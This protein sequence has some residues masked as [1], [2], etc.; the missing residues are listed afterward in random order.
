MLIALVAAGAAWAWW[1]RRRMQKRQL[2][3]L[4]RAAGPSARRGAII[5]AV[6]QS[7]AALVAVA[8]LAFSVW[9]EES[10][11]VFWLRMP[12]AVLVIAIYVPYAAVLAPVRVNVKNLRRTPQRRMVESGARPDVADAIARAGQPFALIGSLIFLAAVTVLVW[13]HLRN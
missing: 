3:W 10:H 5:T 7:L 1:A 8:V 6:S 4:V 2:A 11:R 13:H 9:V 12:L